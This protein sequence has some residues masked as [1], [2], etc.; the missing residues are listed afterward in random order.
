M[1]GSTMKLGQRGGFLLL[2]SSTE[3]LTRKDTLS[4]SPPPLH[5]VGAPQSQRKGVACIDIGSPGGIG[6]RKLP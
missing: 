1:E 5:E 4:A 2:N 3:P 6:W